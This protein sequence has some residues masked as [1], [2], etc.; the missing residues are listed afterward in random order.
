MLDQEKFSPRNKKVKLKKNRGRTVSSKQWLERQLNDVYV[1]EAKKMGYRSRAAFKLIELNEKFDFLKEESR[2][3]DLGAAPGGWTQVVA[4]AVDT[5]LENSQIIG[6]DLLDI[7]PIP[8]TT[9]ILGDFTDEQVIDSVK[10]L[11]TGPADLVLS[12]MA[13][14][15]TGHKQT[16]HL[17]IIALVET[18]FYFA[19]DVLREG[20]TFIAKVFQGGTEPSLLNI[21]KQSFGSVKHVKPKSSRKESSELYLVAQNFKKRIQQNQ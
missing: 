3:I 11:L 7:E 5:N 2:V 20:G 18:A 14:S 12:D 8:N 9:L 4:K 10:N 19:E 17:R 1:Q 16:D 15:T 13:P 6:I 21:L